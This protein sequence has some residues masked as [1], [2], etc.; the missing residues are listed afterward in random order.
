MDFDTAVLLACLAVVGTVAVIAHHLR[1]GQRLVV[2]AG[3]AALVVQVFC[4]PCDFPD[5]TTERRWM[6]ANL[7]Y[8][9][10]G[11][12]GS[13]SVAAG[14]Q[15]ICLA[16]TIALTAASCALLEW[17]HRRRRASTPATQ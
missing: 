10:R 3:T 7:S 8:K 12:T 15:A 16:A 1:R 14:Q 9:Y 4:P 6:P 2:L 17:R 5:G 11:D 13:P